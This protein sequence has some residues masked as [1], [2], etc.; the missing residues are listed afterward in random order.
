MSRRAARGTTNGGGE[1]GGSSNRS[2]DTDET[3]DLER[4]ASLLFLRQELEQR[5]EAFRS[6]FQRVEAGSG[7]GEGGGGREEEEEGSLQRAEGGDSPG[8][9]SRSIFRRLMQHHLILGRSV[10]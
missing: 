4:L 6:V 1:G 9:S 5:Q 7:G 10:V 2:T 8:A 3:R